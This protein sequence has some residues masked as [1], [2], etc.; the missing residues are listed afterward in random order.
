MI[1]YNVY[2]YMPLL[3]GATPETNKVG[4]LINPSFIE[5]DELFGFILFIGMNSKK[6]ESSLNFPII[7]SIGIVNISFGFLLII[8]FVLIEPA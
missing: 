1:S 3:D 4:T 5:I 7:S 6:S 2:S 8:K